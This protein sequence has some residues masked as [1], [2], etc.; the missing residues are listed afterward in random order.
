M[1]RLDSSIL[2]I[3]KQFSYVLKDESAHLQTS[4]LNAFFVSA[5]IIVE[6]DLSTVYTK[7]VKELPN[8]C[9]CSKPP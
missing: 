9:E 1:N 5:M 2:E 8:R 6:L 4:I 7:L 3:I